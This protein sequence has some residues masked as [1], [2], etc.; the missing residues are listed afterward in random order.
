MQSRTS[1][2]MCPI[3]VIIM[4]VDEQQ[5]TPKQQGL[6]G[7]QAFRYSPQAV[8]NQHTTSTYSIP[9]QK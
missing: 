6:T 4:V 5:M 1:R 3:L 2:T 7:A 9:N 8:N